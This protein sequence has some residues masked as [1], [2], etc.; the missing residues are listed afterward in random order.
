MLAGGVVEHEVD[1][2]AHAPLVQL[3][4][5]L[6]EV[7][8]RAQPRVDRAV[9]RDR[10]AAVVLPGPRLQQRHEV[11]VGGAE[12]GEVVQLARQLGERAAE[13]VDVADVALHPGPLE[14]ARVDLPPAVQPPQRGRA[15]GG[16][17]QRDA[18]RRARTARRRR[19]VRVEPGQRLVH[20]G[21][22]ELD[23]RQ[24]GVGLVRPERGD[25]VLGQAPAAPPPT[26]AAAAA[27]ASVTA[28]PGRS[29]RQYCRACSLRARR[30]TCPRTRDRRSLED[31]IE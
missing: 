17:G 18:Q 11:Q 1:A 16:R 26:P 28:A 31:V 4:G 12:L 19:P 10:V 15:L 25:R 27:R 23:P 30:S 29:P 22:R 3:P 13:A 21:Q 20:V 8:H 7:G 14:P 2:Q 5:D 6:L 24:E 9:V